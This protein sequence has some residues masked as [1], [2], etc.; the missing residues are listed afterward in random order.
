MVHL[1]YRRVLILLDITVL[2][3][4]TDVGVKIGN[5]QAYSAKKSTANQNKPQNNQYQA[6]PVNQSSNQS[7]QSSYKNTPSVN[8]NST[9]NMSLNE[10]LTHPINSLSPYQNK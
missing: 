1:L 5:P 8:T 9:M 2:H 3:K 6:P 4:G 10:H 7:Y